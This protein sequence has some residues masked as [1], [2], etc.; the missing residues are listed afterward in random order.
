MD[1]GVQ[2]RKGFS[3][4]T[5]A[6][7]NRTSDIRE[8]DSSHT[9]DFMQNQ[10]LLN[11]AVWLM[12]IQPGEHRA[13]RNCVNIF[14]NYPIDTL[15]NAHR[16]RTTV[17]KNFFLHWS[18]D[19]EVSPW[20]TFNSEVSPIRYATAPLDPFAAHGRRAADGQSE[21]CILYVDERAVFPHRIERDAKRHVP[22]L[23]RSNSNKEIARAPGTVRQV[24]GKGLIE[25][26]HRDLKDH[27]EYRRNSDEAKDGGKQLVS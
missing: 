3:V 2:S 18:S 14:Q 12:E 6:K 16:T 1:Y 17:Q 11:R 25:N 26:L 22:V 4:T 23:V 20:K 5:N 15:C 10:G 9:L 21:G 13:W 24:Q 8:I 19:L 27:L 7:A